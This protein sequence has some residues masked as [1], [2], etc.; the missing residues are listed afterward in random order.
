MKRLFGCLVGALVLLPGCLTMS[1]S[2]K[3][4]ARSFQALAASTVDGMS[5]ERFLSAR[6]VRVV[7]QPELTDE[8][9]VVRAGAAT[10]VPITSDGYALTVAHALD[11]LP[12][13][14]SLPGE[15]RGRRLRVVWDGFRDTDAKVDLALIHI[16]GPLPAWFELAGEEALGKGTPVAAAGFS[17]AG[18]LVLAG[19]ELMSA[20]PQE[21]RLARVIAHTTP[22]SFGDS[23]GPLTLLDGR[24]VGINFGS[25]IAPLAGRLSSKAMRPNLDWLA[26]LIK[27]D[28]DRITS[29]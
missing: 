21:N 20:S 27:N 29:R 7:I 22:L 26:G 8:R 12:V 13:F 25:T 24:L 14:V 6:A 19:G 3:D 17:D 4:K 23:G 18:E 15:K 2:M 10:A 11:E 1:A 28:R 5:L 16:R 9:G